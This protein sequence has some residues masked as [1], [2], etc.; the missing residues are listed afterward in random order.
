MG[1][2]YTYPLITQSA[3]TCF[4]VNKTSPPTQRAYVWCRIVMTITWSPEDEVETCLVVMERGDFPDL[5]LLQASSSL[6]PPQTSLLS[7]CAT[8]DLEQEEEEEQQISQRSG[9]VPLVLC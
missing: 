8:E 3:K 9:G 2:D 6:P 7:S 1:I 4:V 5:K